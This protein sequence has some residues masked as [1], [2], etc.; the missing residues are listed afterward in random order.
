MFIALS[1]CRHAYFSFAII[2]KFRVVVVTPLHDSLF[3]GWDCQNFGI[4]GSATGCRELS[5]LLLNDRRGPGDMVHLSRIDLNLLVVLDAIYSEGG[6]TKA[7]ERLHLTQSAVSHALSRLRELFND[8]VFERQ[9]HRMVPTALTQRLIEP[10]RDTLRSLSSLLNETQRFEPASSSKRFTLGFRGFME[11]TLVPSVVH[12]ALAEAP[13]VQISCVTHHRRDVEAELAA[14]TIDLI[15]DVL[16][17]L[18]EAIKFTRLT[19]DRMVVVARRG[20]PAIQQALDMETYLAQRHVLVTPRRV[21]PAFEDIELRRLGLQRRVSLRCRNYD[22]ACHAVSMTDLF[23]T[24]PE[25]YAH[26]ANRNFNNVVLPT[27]AS[28][29]SLDGYMYWHSSS[30]ADPANRWL[31]TVVMSAARERRIEPLEGGSAQRTE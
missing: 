9:S 1:C 3:R 6:I 14:G 20:H 28:F 26:L 23:L 18:S 24:M 25:N 11:S 4:G 15:V 12:H 17:P 7:A 16:L 22:T 19:A 5:L 27:P 13:E 21:G 29:Q 30:D 10:L 2:K 8:P 31:R